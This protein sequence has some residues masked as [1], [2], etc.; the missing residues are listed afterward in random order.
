MI[1][2]IDKDLNLSI[3]TGIWY[4]TSE[5][6]TGYDPEKNEWEITSNYEGDLLTSY[7]YTFKE[8][9]EGLDKALGTGRIT[10]VDYTYITDRMK[11]IQNKIKT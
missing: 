8:I 3:A 7:T 9:I 10:G 6:I 2:L 5:E 4:N 1:D 11:M